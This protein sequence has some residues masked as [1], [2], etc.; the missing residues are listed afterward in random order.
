[1]KEK[2]ISVFK[3]SLKILFITALLLNLISLYK[4]RNVETANIPIKDIKLI[5][6]TAFDHKKDSPLIIH[7]WATWCPVCKIENRTIEELSKDHQVVTV[8]VE[9][10]DD[11][12]IKEF[13][14]KNNLTFKTVNDTNRTL[15]ES[16]N[17][18]GYPT[19]L[20]YG[21]NGRHLFTEVGYTSTLG[22]KLRLLWA[23]L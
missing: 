16:F 21:K 20:V 17:I 7:F 5:D 13:M 3:E 18:Q 8:A 2:I 12:T 23:D 6:G 9:S 14:E 10:G 19:T 1:M 15:A 22:L 11:K 4:S